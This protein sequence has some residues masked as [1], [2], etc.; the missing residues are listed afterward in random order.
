VQS[1][2]IAL[3][4][5]ILVLLVWR[6]VSRER[7][8]YAR[9]KALRS[10]KLRQKVYR[11]WLVES[12]LVMGGLTI[13]VLLAA[14]P[15]VPQVLAQAQAWPPVA[16]LRE[17]FATPVGAIVAV[18]AGI[19]FVLV[20]VLPAFLLRDVDEVPMVGDI[21]ALLPRNNAELPYGAGLA[22]SAGIFEETLFRLGLPAL[23]FGITGDAAIAFLGCAV[24]FGLL[25]LYQRVVGVVTATVLGLLLTLAYVVSGSI[26]LAIAIHALID[27][28][29]LVLLPMLINR[30]KK[31]AAAPTRPSEQP[32]APSPGTTPRADPPPTR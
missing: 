4:L 29:S 25:H 7:R 24:L 20:M 19:V 8:E 28:R 11:R 23:V 14:G 15:Y 9:F 21:G 10:T 17:A 16:W 27:L 13:A 12:V 26:L 1:A 30:S 32:P 5:V 31:T 2:L 22:L 6:A 18:A 3:L